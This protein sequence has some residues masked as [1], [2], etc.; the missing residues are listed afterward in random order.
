MKKKASVFIIALLFTLLPI[1][2]MANEG[3]ANSGQELGSVHSKYLMTIK[4]NSG[5][6]RFF[7]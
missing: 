4:T 2:Q 7:T 1:M 6:F 3:K 5:S